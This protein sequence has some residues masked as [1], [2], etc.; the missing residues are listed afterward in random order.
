MEHELA[1]AYETS[2]Q[3]F[4]HKTL[5]ID[6]VKDAGT[7]QSATELRRTFLEFNPTHLILLGD[8]RMKEHV[9]L[10]NNLL[11]EFRLKGIKIIVILMDLL[12]SHKLMG[13]DLVRF[14]ID[15][16]DILIV[17]NSRILNH[18]P[19]RT[20]FLLWPS[21]PFPEVDP[22]LNENFVQKDHL[23]IL[24]SQHR[25][26]EVFAKYALKNGLTVAS[27]LSSRTNNFHHFPTWEQYMYRVQ[28]SKL[29]FTNG[30]RNFRE[31][32]VI[33]RTTEVMLAKSVLL[34]ESGSDID[35]F[36]KP[37]FDYVP[38]NS[39][40]DLVEKARFL[41][42]NE[43]ERKFIQQNAF[44][45]MKTKYSYETFWDLLAKKLE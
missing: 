43:E 4:G 25:Q 21:L 20:N 9:G 38:I 32:Q 7:H 31:S 8:T 10:T 13:R 28:E 45:T 41:L 16:A 2:A 22:I 1:M 37:Y 15:K 30:Y 40:S 18:F 24:G 39:L 6:P 44:K 12:F 33:A 17:H 42:S 36:F 11:A 3:L 23:L 35:F 14:W 34:Y 26:R 27:E 29:V 5:F 19:N